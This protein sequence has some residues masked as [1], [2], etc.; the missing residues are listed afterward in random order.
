M[1]LL[2]K[3][4]VDLLFFL[5]IEILLIFVKQCPLKLMSYAINDGQQKS[6]QNCYLI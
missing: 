3:N 4:Y 6:L 2:C 1:E 5:G